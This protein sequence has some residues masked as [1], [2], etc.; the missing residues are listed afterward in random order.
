MCL[1]IPGKI[2]KIS[3]KGIVIDYKTSE[4]NILN[5]IVENIKKGDWVLVENKFITRKFSPTQV[6]E[7]FKLINNEE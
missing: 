7:F 5:S 2:K 6:K 3:K 1:A 4:V